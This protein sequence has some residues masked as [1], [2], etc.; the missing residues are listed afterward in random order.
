MTLPTPA[1]SDSALAIGHE[2]AASSSPD[3]PSP[4]ALLAAAG[5][6][7]RARLLGSGYGAVAYRAGD[8]VLRVL[9]PTNPASITAGYEREHTLLALLANHGLPV[10]REAQ[11]LRGEDGRPLATLHR[12]VEG[13]PAHRAGPGGALLRG[14]ARQRLAEELGRFLAALHTTPV[15]EARA[16]GVPSLDA[17]RDA[18]TTLVAESAPEL[19]LRT[20]AWVEAELDRFLDAGGSEAAPRVLIHGDIASAHLLARPDGSLAG[21]ID[22]ADALTADPARDIAGFASGFGSLR[23]FRPPFIRRAL[24]SYAAEGGRAARVAADPDLDRRVRFYLAIEPLYQVRYGWMLGGTAGEAQ[25][26]TGRRRLAA[27]ARTAASR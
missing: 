25:V 12:Y 15:R 18:Y 8:R 20:R 16:L 6:E 3:A 4:R 13:A 9:R 17:G 2:A 10:P 21:V 23:G 1:P 26:E 14:R 5:V 22:W 27:R 11:L 7:E 24:A 19:G